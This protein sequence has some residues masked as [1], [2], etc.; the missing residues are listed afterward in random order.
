MIELFDRNGQIRVPNGADDK[1]RPVYRYQAPCNRCGGAGG[2]E[3]WRHTGWTCYDC[4]GDGKGAVRSM[5]LYDAAKLA[6][7]NA[8]AARKAEKKAAIAAAAAAAKRA[9]MDA[10]WDGWAAANPAAGEAAK[11]AALCGPDA[12][13]GKLAAMLA[14]REIPSDRMLDVAL[15]MVLDKLAAA[16]LREA[17]QYVGE[18]GKRIVLDL[19][20]ER[21]IDLG[22]Y[23]Y[24]A[25]RTWLNLCRDAA[26]NRVIYKGSAGFGDGRWKATVKE[27]SVYE[28]ERQTMIARPVAMETEAA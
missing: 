8:I 15:A 27:H 21:S 14:K 7:L 18:V 1:G 26:G 13:P 11:H 23:C 25:P 5:K 17:S 28:G 2:S 3:A 16:D 9:E 24:G 20:V 6:K 22:A 12:L 10:A 4:G 19:V